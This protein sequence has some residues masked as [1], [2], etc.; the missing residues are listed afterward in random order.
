MYRCIYICIY[1]YTYTGIV[2][3]VFSM[4]CF[5]HFSPMYQFHEHVLS[6]DVFFLGPRIFV[7]QNGRKFQKK[8]IIVV[9]CE[10]KWRY[11][12]V[13]NSRPQLP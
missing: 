7:S 10:Y 8:K 12:P 11:N 13:D 6:L 1:L 5:T 3:V 4:S 2:Y 9:R